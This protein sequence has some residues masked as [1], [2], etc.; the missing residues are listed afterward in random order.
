MSF[1]R[2]FSRLSTRNKVGVIVCSGVVSLAGYGYMYGFLHFSSG[3]GILSRRRA[4]IKAQ[5]KA[6]TQ[7]RS[8]PEEFLEPGAHDGKKDTSQ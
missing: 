1:L 2:Q 6:G 5:D 4:Q 8:N 7:V 3:D